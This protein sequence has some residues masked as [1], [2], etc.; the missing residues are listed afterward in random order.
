MKRAIFR[1]TIGTFE[2]NL[3]DAD[4][5]MTYTRDNGLDGKVSCVRIVRH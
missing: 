4:V 1:K 5:K 3:D 2:R